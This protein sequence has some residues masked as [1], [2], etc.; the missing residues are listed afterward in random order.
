MIVRPVA[1]ADLAAV[2]DIYAHYV[3]HSIVSF[4]E[5]PPD[6]QV[7]GQRHAAVTGVG[8]PYLCAEIDGAV[9]GFAYAGPYGTRAAYRYTVEDSVYIAPA[10]Q[11]RGVGKALLSA[12]IADCEAL[13][14][15]QMLA[16]IGDSDNTGSIALHAA[17]GFTPAGMGKSVGWKKGRWVDI[18]WMQRALNGGAE[19]APAGDGVLR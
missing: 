1:A 11:G 3:L 18:V 9:V 8:L 13:G 7:M 12:V 2:A 16:V 4:E 14:L 19:T 15:C 6:A 10:F 5:V 17:L